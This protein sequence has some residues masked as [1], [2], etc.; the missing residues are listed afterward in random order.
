MK[1]KLEKREKKNTINNK[2]KNNK[3]FHV[4]WRNDCDLFPLISPMGIALCTDS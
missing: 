4:L 2:N 1:M 3:I